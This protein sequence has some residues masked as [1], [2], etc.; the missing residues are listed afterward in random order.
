MSSWEVSDNFLSYNGS[1]QGIRAFDSGIDCVEWDFGVDFLLNPEYSEK[2]Q[3]LSFNKIDFFVEHVLQKSLFVSADDEFWCD[4]ATVEKLNTNYVQLPG[5]PLDDLVTKIL[6]RK[7]QSITQPYIIILGINVHNSSSKVRFHYTDIENVVFP[8]M[9]EW[10]TGNLRFHDKPWWERNDTD[11][12]D[13]VPINQ[14][15]VDNPPK[16]SVSF[17]A[18]YEIFNDKNNNKSGKVIDVREKFK[19][20]IV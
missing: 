18:L 9:D 11:T 6:F 10:I 19:P 12:F 16:N 4:N 7:L 8:H 5:Q 20:K 13:V 14:E 1:F 3:S 2:D 15:E 17:Q